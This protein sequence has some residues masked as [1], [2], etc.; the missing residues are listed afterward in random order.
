[1]KRL[2][3]L[4]LLLAV[5][6]GTRV[7]LVYDGDTFMTSDSARVRLLGIDAPESYQPGGDISR[8]ML[9]KLVLSRDVRLEADVVGQDDYGR[10]LRYVWVGDTMVNA[11]LVAR[12]YAVPR[13]FQDSLRY[14]DTLL[15]L[16][17]SAARTGRGLW[18]FNVFQPPTLE[19]L[20]ARVAAESTTAETTAGGLQVVSWLDAGNYIGRLVAVE[21]TVVATHN[22]GRVC[23]LNFHQ[24]YRRYFTV[25]IFGQ[26]FGKFPPQP[27]NHYLRRRVRV[28]GLVKEYKGAP[29]IIANDPGQ[30]EI[31]GQ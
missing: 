20:R 4:V 29:E 25:A 8:D 26:D 5:A 9:E 16:E 19:L 31:L 22:S 15:A 12:G 24:D 13:M 27:E 30:I 10:L 21:G 23:H 14:W 6:T 7:V 2:L 18:S 11:E 17:Q 28:T 3:G 1:M